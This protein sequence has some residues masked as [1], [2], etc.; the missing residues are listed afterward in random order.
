MDVCAEVLEDPP[1]NVLAVVIIEVSP[2]FGIGVYINFDAK[3]SEAELTVLESTMSTS[4][5]VM[6]RFG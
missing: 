2:I 5:G 6:L 3:M 4:L 1:L